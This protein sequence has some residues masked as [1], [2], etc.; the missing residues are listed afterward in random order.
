M[1]RKHNPSRF[2][3]AFTIG[4][5]AITQMLAVVTISSVIMGQ[6]LGVIQLVIALIIT[7]SLSL[8]FVPELAQ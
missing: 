2:H 5:F 6:G 1:S 8:V 4:F 3:V 7:Q